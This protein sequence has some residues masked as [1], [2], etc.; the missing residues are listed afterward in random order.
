[1]TDQTTDWMPKVKKEIAL[2]LALVFVGV[3]L[4][5]IVVYLVGDK[6]FGEYSG[7]GFA[8]FFGTL[9]SDLRAGHSVVWFLVLS[10]YLVWQFLRLTMWGF[11]QTRH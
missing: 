11:R 7:A 8:A 9:H 2:F 1:M 4:L 3:L 6:V 10:P 5:P